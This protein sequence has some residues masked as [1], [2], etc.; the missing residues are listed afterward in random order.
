MLPGLKTTNNAHVFFIFLNYLF[1]FKRADNRLRKKVQNV[2]I[3]VRETA[4]GVKRQQTPNSGQKTQQS[5][6]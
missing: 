2:M 5:S 3:K 1:K 4:I 6:P